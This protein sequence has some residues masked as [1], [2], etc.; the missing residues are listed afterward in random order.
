M[1][2]CSLPFRGV[3]SGPLVSVSNE[4][5]SEQDFAFFPLASYPGGKALRKRRCSDGNCSG[6]GWHLRAPSLPWWRLRGVPG[7][8]TEATFS[9][10]LHGAERHFAFVSAALRA[11]EYIKVVPQLFP[12][13]QGS[14][15]IPCESSRIC[16]GL[17]VGKWGAGMPREP[18]LA[19]LDRAAAAWKPPAAAAPWGLLSAAPPVLQSW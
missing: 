7:S 16:S 15:K 8:G 10:S 3:S 11:V 19:L 17:A 18:A 4:I 9:L 6:T 12:R 14:C 2:A 5:T 1:A 13:F